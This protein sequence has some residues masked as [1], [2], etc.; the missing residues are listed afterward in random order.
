[1]SASPR[2]RGPKDLIPL[3]FVLVSVAYPFVVWLNIDTIDPRWFG[4]VLLLVSIFRLVVAGRSRKTSDWLMTAVIAL[5]CAGVIFLNSEILLKCYPVIMS[6]GMGLLFLISL[7]DEHTLIER[8]ARA[9][10][11][12]PPA[13][14]KG[15]L[16]AL[17][18]AWGLLL[19]L[20]AAVAAW[21]AWFSSL[22]VWTLYNG[23]LSYLIFAVF[24]VAELLFRRHYKKKHKIVDD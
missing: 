14:A 18:L 13:Q 6:A 9:G 1:M 10:G 12:N 21:T 2:Q 11:H 7:L 15:Y 22:A 3:L 17:S 20:N 23:L 5:Y 24:V 16:R 4:A 19:L 8:F